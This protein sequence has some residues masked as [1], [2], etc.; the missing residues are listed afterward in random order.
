MESKIQ[1]KYQITYNCGIVQI[2]YLI[3]HDDYVNIF[4]V[5]KEKILE[6]ETKNNFKETKE[7]KSLKNDLRI[8][9]GNDFFTDKSPL[10]DA[11]LTGILKLTKNQG[12]VRP[13]KIIK[14]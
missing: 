6:I 13:C 5:Y 12:G 7:T 9:F 3:T 1:G 14:M 11:Y 2:K 10:F 4:K 8:M